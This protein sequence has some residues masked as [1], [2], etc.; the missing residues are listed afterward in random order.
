MGNKTS[1]G[2][3]KNAEKRREAKANLIFKFSY[4]ENIQCMVFKLNVRK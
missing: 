2:F 4:Y 3:C 1:S